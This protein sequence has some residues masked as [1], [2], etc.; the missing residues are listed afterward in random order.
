[1]KQ[2]VKKGL[3]YQHHSSQLNSVK[4]GTL[5]PIME[6]PR[7]AIEGNFKAV[8]F[9]KTFKD[10]KQIFMSAQRRFKGNFNY[11]N[12]IMENVFSS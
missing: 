9:N 3:G 8:L 10:S 4:S 5:T 2:K 6:S 7:G 12:N 1:M 11:T